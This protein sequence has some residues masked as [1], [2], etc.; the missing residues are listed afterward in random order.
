MSDFIQ[1]HKKMYLPIELHVYLLNAEIVSLYVDDI[2]VIVV[3]KSIERFE[4]TN[5]TLKIVFNKIWE[6][7]FC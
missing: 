7:S 6:I 5:D 3:G 2:L 4:A 1:V